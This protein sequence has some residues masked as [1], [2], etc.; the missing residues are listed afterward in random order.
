MAYKLIS[1]SYLLWITDKI[2]L[3]PMKTKQEASILKIKITFTFK[4]ACVQ[5]IWR[6][7]H[8]RTSRA[9]STFP[10][11]ANKQR[12]Y[13]PDFGVFEAAWSA[14]WILWHYHKAYAKRN[15]FFA[16]IFV[17]FALL[18][19]TRMF[20]VFLF[21]LNEVS[22]YLSAI[23]MSYLVTANNPNGPIT[24]NRIHQ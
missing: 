1:F 3:K 18:H 2:I 20:L 14:Y 16:D 22:N 9:D 10:R 13:A 5:I 23:F 21:G 7:A 4:E 24:K 11:A 15:N 6:T 17:L 8:A 12:K 19:K